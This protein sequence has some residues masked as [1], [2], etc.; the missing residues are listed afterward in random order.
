MHSSEA[1]AYEAKVSGNKEH[2]RIVREA[3]QTAIAG[4]RKVMLSGDADGQTGYMSGSFLF[5]PFALEVL[6][7]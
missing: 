3:L 5:A 1:I 6:N 2:R 4:G 7:D